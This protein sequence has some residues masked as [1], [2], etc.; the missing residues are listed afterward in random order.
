MDVNLIQVYEDANISLGY[1]HTARDNTLEYTLEV[2]N[3][4]NGIDTYNLSLSGAPG[5]WNVTMS[6][7][8]LSLDSGSN[9]NLTINIVIPYNSTERSATLSITALS[10]TNMTSTFDLDVDLSNL[11]IGEEEF[12]VSGDQVTKGEINTEPIPGFEAVF[13]IIALL[14]VAVIIKRRDAK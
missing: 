8:E 13:L 11:R 14:F 6:A 5:D 4:G 12:R 1:I 3:E 7:T 2:A 9:E 10:S